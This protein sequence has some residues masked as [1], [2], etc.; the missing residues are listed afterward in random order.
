MNQ[1]VGREIGGAGR[2]GDV[3]DRNGEGTGRGQQR[4]RWEKWT[5]QVGTGRREGTKVPVLRC[6]LYKSGL[7]WKQGTAMPRSM[8]PLHPVSKQAFVI[9]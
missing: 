4:E 2:A 5:E 1:A 3:S 7:L 6:H 8:R 9:E